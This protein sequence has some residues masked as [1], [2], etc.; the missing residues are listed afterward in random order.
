M[1][2]VIDM[3]ARTAIGSCRSFETWPY[4]TSMHLIW[5]MS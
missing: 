3:T 5:V 1:V 4:Q 2:P